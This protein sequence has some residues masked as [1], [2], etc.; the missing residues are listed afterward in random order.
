M[1]LSIASF[2]LLELVV[3]LRWFLQLLIYVSG[4]IDLTGVC[5][6]RYRS[7]CAYGL[8]IY[9]VFELAGT[10]WYSY[11]LVAVLFWAGSAAAMDWCYLK[12]LR[13]STSGLGDHVTSDGGGVSVGCPDS[14]ACCLF[15]ST[16]DLQV[17]EPRPAGL[18]GLL[19]AC[20]CCRLNA[21][22]AWT[23]FYSLLT[24]G[25][26]FVVACYGV[27]QMSYIPFLELLLCV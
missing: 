21:P 20:P 6:E 26:F 1:R 16:H 8:G 19:S 3:T 12:Q 23:G 25:A 27:L 22:E 15:P 5:S 4:L 10:R 11:S 9:A 24:F 18:C 2:L 14:A 7:C 13:C 17:N